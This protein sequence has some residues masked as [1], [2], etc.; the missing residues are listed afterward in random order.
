MMRQEQTKGI[1][2]SQTQKRAG[3]LKWEK[4]A[5]SMIMANEMFYV[6]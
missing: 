5:H 3:L 6:N 4:L 1:T 2:G